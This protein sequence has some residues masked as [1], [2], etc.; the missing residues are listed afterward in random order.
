MDL[1]KK[2]DVNFTDYVDLMNETSIRAS[3]LALEYIRRLGIQNYFSDL[4]RDKDFLISP[5]A[6][7]LI[8]IIYGL[9]RNELSKR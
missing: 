8:G 9:A 4:G 2:I 5:S 1:I 7:Q 6:I 3:E